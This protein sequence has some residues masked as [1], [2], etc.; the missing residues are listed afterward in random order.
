[1]RL[2][3]LEQERLEKDLRN[4]EAQVLEAEIAKQ[5]RKEKDSILDELVSIEYNFVYLIINAV[6]PEIHTYQTTVMHP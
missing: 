2:T 6:H 4:K 5:K 3:Q 1:M